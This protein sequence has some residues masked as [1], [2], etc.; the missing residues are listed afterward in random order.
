MDDEHFLEF[1]RDSQQLT[2]IRQDES[3]FIPHLNFETV[4]LPFL[5]LIEKEYSKNNSVQV[6]PRP[7]LR[8]KERYTA[9]VTA[10]S[11]G[12]GGAI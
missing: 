8:G 1:L 4:H 5:D 10:L 11:C 2:L 6:S 12:R 9:L 3:T 7:S